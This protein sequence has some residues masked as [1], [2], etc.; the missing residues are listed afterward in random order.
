MS[1]ESKPPEGGAGNGSP[2]KPMTPLELAELI[3]KIRASIGGLTKIAKATADVLHKAIEYEKG[4]PHLGH[5]F[6]V[7]L[8]LL[9]HADHVMEPVGGVSTEEDVHQ[10][11][12]KIRT[13]CMALERALY[14]CVHVVR[15]IVSLI[16]NSSL[17]DISETLGA[18]G[19]VDDGVLNLVRAFELIGEELKPPATTQ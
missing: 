19:D 7:V 18:L 4:E 8:V 12:E 11:R 1:E 3:E 9:V 10:Q 5:C 17:D 13:T 16:K 6:D 14:P 2:S 15:A